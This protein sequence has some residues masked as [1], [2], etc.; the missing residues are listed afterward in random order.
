[1]LP[2]VLRLSDETETALGGA[3]GGEG[4]LDGGCLVITGYEGEA[5]DVA[6]RRG[7]ATA[8]LQ[9]AGGRP[10]GPERGEQWRAGR[11]RAPALR[12]DLLELGVLAETLETATTW[13][14]LEQLHDTV[15]AALR[16][17]LP[18]SSPLVLCHVSHVYPAGASLYFTIVARRDE[19][20]PAGQWLTAKRAAGDAI[21]AAGATITHHHA[22]G[23]DHRAW[24]AAEVGE[25]GLEALRAVKERLDPAGVLNP[26]KLL[27]PR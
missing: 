17:A 14:G 9:R 21:A 5:E 25:L 18:G 13:A 26:G 10:L 8:A 12:D 16:E 22:I 19:H 2:D 20:D 7:R 11:Y 15:A 1:V 27:P 23:L 24:M 3:L 6:Y 4:G